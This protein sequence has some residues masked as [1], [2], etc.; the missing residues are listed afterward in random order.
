MTFSQESLEQA[1]MADGHPMSNQRL[2][3]VWDLV[4][5][6]FNWKDRID[7]LVPMEEATKAE[8]ETAVRWYTG[9]TPEVVKER[10]HTWHVTGEGYYVRSGKADVEVLTHP[11]RC[12]ADRARIW[13]EGYVAGRDDYRGRVDV[14]HQ[15]PNPYRSMAEAGESDA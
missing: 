8:I 13:A 2:I 7:A 14:D 11:P 15:T 12:A 6:R 3:E 5:N 10:G 9:G 4:K 1:R